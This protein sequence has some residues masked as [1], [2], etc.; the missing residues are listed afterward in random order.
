MFKRATPKL[1]HPPFSA[2]PVHYIRAGSS[3]TRIAFHIHG[4]LSDAT[5]PIICLPGYVR[6]MLDFA[7]LPATINRLP[8]TEFTFVLVDLPGRGRS[9][10]LPKDTSYSTL[11]DADCLLDL[12][13]ALDVSR[14]IVMGEGHGGQVAMIAAHRQPSAIGGAILI[15]AG[16]VTDSRAL[17][18]MRSNFRYLD[19]LRGA[20]VLR[21]ALRKILAADY[22][23]ETEA[24]LDNLIERIFAIDS[25]GRIAPLFDLR[26]IVQLEQ[27]D[28][29]DAMAPQ[30]P[31]FHCLDHV[32]MMV[33]KT[34]LS[35]QIRR[36]TFEE[37][38]RRRPDAAMLHI[39]GE[40]S[41]AL[42]QDPE[43]LEALAIFLRSSCRPAID[44]A[45][46]GVAVAE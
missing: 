28:F 11:G 7:A 30:W 16:P 33:V 8:D 17:V 34:Q 36:A 42:L 5:M 14:A 41:P 40:G 26:L 31:L 4:A 1:E 21:G 9:S 15:D 19:G 38:A 27:F 24:R 45:A 20:S 3:G 22:P 25:R 35:D 43:E 13:A 44:T 23:G 39:S 29:D 12:L 37:M 2:L 10:A 18:R 32:P 46:P 6:N